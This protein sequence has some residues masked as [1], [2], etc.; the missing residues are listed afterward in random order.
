MGEGSGDA[1]GEEDV[2]RSGCWDESGSGRRRDGAVEESELVDAAWVR[3]EAGSN[4]I[5]KI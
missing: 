2:E 1:E 4:W 5:G 3:R